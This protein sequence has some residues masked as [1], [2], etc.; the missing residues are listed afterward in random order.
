MIDTMKAALDQVMQAASLA[1][2]D[3][4]YL[5]CEYKCVEALALARQASDWAYYARILMPLQ[6][7]RRQRRMIAAEGM[8]RLGSQGLAGAPEQ[9]LALHPTACIVLTQPHDRQT[10]STLRAAA[11]ARHQHVEVLLADCNMDADQWSLRSFAGPEVTLKL[12]PPPVQWRDQWMPGR[13]TGTDATPATW[14]LDAGEAL[15]DAA[16]ALLGDHAADRQRLEALEHCLEVVTDHEAIHH[17]LRDAA[18][19]LA[20]ADRGRQSSSG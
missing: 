12:A 10:A 4:D 14:F 6:E 5:L 7:S 2:A 18:V 1:L 9:W 11:A 16:T 8:I 15:G 3:R 17:R 20:H 19:A 13:V